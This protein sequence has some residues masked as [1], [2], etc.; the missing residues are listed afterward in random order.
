M[1]Y[2]TV[3]GAG[4][5]FPSNPSLR[6]F[7]LS[8]ST[9][10]EWPTEVSVTS[11][12]VADIMEVTP[13]AGSL[14]MTLPSAAL[15]SPGQMIMFTNRGSFDYLVQ[16]AAGLSVALVIPGS[17][18]MIYIADNSSVGGVWRAVQFGSTTTVAQAATLAGFGLQASGGLLVQTM[19]VRQLSSDYTFSGADRAAAIIWVSGAGTLTLP[20]AASVGSNW[21]V[22]IKNAGTGSVTL[23]ASSSLVDSL[24]SVSLEPN[25]GC[26]VVTDGLTFYT[27]ARTTSSASSGFDFLTVSVAG[28]G[29]YTIAGSQLN[30]I[31]YKLSGLLTGNR[32]FIVP[33]TVQQYWINNQTSG[34]FTITV[35]TAAGS[36]VVVPQGQS[37][38]LYCDGTSVVNAATAGIS[39]PVGIADGGTGAT[40]ASAARSN[41]GATSLGD[42]LFT[43]PD[44]ATARNNLGT[45]S[46]AEAVSSDLLVA[47]LMS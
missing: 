4:V 9:V 14:V 16:T 44:A 25:E 29:D 39:V 38:V 36:G 13:S 11:N 33:A 41:L 21:F 26:I 10:L 28:T 17:T 19:P 12:V 37:A 20:T 45:L 46:G 24:A 1:S 18:W 8:A 31:A 30:R 32:N 22:N 15:A 42:A 23:S 40:T 2:S 47:L 3:F 5:V 6:E 35:K 27:L 34:A 7:P 43:T